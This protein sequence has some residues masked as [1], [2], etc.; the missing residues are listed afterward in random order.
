MPFAA[1]L[2]RP[3][4]WLLIAIVVLSFTTTILYKVHTHD[5]EKIGALQAARAD[6]IADAKACSDATEKLR[7]E[8]EQRAAEVA[9]RLKAAE[10]ARHRAE[11]RVEQT[12]QERPINPNDLCASAQALNQKMLHER[13][14]Q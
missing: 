10:E 11:Q 14:P 12:L 2:L 3:T 9:A 13:R 6:A 4:T 8:A 1:L 7:K 5:L